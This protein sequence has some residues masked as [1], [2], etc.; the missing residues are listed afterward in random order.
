MRHPRGRG[1]GPEVE[2]L[3]PR[4]VQL[5]PD[6]HEGV[7]VPGLSLLLLHTLLARR[8]VVEQEDA[9]TEQKFSHCCREKYQITLPDYHVSHQRSYG[10]HVNQTF[11]IQHHC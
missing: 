1:P 11:E 6:A 9:D 5:V 10:H 8:L 4:A 7:G 2:E 3:G